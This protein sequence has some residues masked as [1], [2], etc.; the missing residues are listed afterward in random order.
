MPVGLLRQLRPE[1]ITCP[2]G[3]LAGDAGCWCSIEQSYIDGHVNPESIEHYCAGDSGVLNGHHQCPTWRA[4]KEQFWADGKPLELEPEKPARLADGF[5]PAQHFA[6]S[7]A[8]EV[9]TE[10]RAYS[11]ETAYAEEPVFDP[12][13]G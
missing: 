4:A 1:E 12:R 11:P 9:M 6:S 5:D 10:E 13:F 7:I 2:A 8:P 3:R